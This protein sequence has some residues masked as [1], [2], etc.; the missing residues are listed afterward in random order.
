[1]H[2]HNTRGTALANIIVA[3]QKGITLF[4]SS[5]AGIGGCPYIPNAT[6]NVATEDLV[7]MLEQMGIEQE[8]T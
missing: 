8:L 1:M 5:I 6:G 4:D 3:L 2:F 7:H